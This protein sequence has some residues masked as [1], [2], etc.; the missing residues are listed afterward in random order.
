MCLR[1]TGNSCWDISSLTLFFHSDIAFVLPYIPINP[2]AAG[3]GMKHLQSSRIFHDRSTAYRLE[4]AAATTHYEALFAVDS[5]LL[6][7]SIQPDE[8]LRA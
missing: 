1:Y 5:S 3:A 2:K 6:A 7:R 4:Q 8:Y